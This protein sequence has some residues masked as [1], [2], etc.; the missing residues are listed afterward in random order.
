MSDT[1]DDKAVG[2]AWRAAVELGLD[3]SL[4]ERNLQKS[5]WE[6]LL[7]HDEALGFAFELRAAGA[8]LYE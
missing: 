3:M 1:S 7:D 5:P 8:K 4:I 2:P 6:R